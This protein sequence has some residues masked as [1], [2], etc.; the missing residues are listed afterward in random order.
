MS[1][2]KGRFFDS[3]G[4]DRKYSAEEFAEYFRSFFTSGLVDVD[5]SLKV[6]AA[7]GMTVGIAYGIAVVNG[8]GYWL[9][10]DTGSTKTLTIPAAHA[11]LPRIDRIVIR[12]DTSVAKRSINLVVKQGVEAPVPAAPALTRTGNI[13]ELSLARVN[14]GAS[15][16]AIIGANITDER[17]D[18][19]L[20]GLVRNIT[21]NR[22]ALSA[23]EKDYSLQIPFG[24]VTT[25]VGNVYSILSPVVASIKAGDAICFIANADAT[26]AVSLNWS[27]TGAKPLI[28]ANG[29][30]VTNLK[31]NG[32]Y[33]VRYSGVN[34][35][36]QGEGASGTATA[37]DLLSGVT[38]GSDAGDL[39]GTMANRG[40]VTITPSTA[41]QAIAAGYHNGLGKV[42]GDA[43]LV[44]A[45]IL[46][47][48]NIFG[49]VG[50]FA[51]RKVASGTATASTTTMQFTK[52]DGTTGYFRYVTVSGLTFKPSTIIIK[53]NIMGQSDILTTY[54][55]ISGG[56]Y[57]K[58]A[59]AGSW[60]G[61]GS[62][63]TETEVKGDVSPA[64]VTAT[65]FT[66]PAQTNA[67]GL[68]MNWIAYE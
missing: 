36:L 39:T 52:V 23:H 21:E 37:A 32:I 54:D 31:A 18:N 7:T 27:G 8:Y 55:E 12:L 5:T 28:K 25:N 48:V 50:S 63:A 65:G 58:G 64:N 35:T 6:T 60:S 56:I 20:C 29:T 66:L 24:G 15:I 19:D 10:A 42:V 43:D 2:E 4:G 9:E 46:S 14:V 41:D 44:P 49:V 68:T 13:Y 38:A 45:N 22:A 3:V 34:F 30:V 17:A 51:G 33:T 1:I 47:G 16:T 26:G 57:A 11:T 40:A 59:K 67:S 62:Q 61:A 53:G